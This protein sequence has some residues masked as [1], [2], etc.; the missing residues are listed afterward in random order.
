MFFNPI[1]DANVR[2]R[3]ARLQSADVDAAG[4]GSALDE[5]RDA[6]MPS[7][8]R[9]S[10]DEDDG[11]L[12]VLWGLVAKIFLRTSDAGHRE[13]AASLLTYLLIYADTH[14]ISVDRRAL[15]Q[16]VAANAQSPLAAYFEEL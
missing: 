2:A 13:N 10:I 16:W 1:V 9:D 4:V 14:S 12:A 5:L 15:K 11:S 8:P 3:I 6:F 7:Y